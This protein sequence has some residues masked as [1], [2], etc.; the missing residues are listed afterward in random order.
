VDHIQIF[1]PFKVSRNVIED[2][3][4]RFTD[5]AIA[6]GIFNDVLTVTVAG[7]T[8]PRCIELS[9]PAGPL[10][11]V[12]CFNVVAGSGIVPAELDVQD[13][14]GGTLLT[15]TSPALRTAAAASSS[16]LA[17]AYFRLRMPTSGGGLLTILRPKDH[18][19]QSGYEVVEYIDFRL[20]EARTLPSSVETKMRAAGV[21]AAELKL[22]AFLTAVPILS[23]IAVSSSQS[24]KM[25]VLEHDL[26]ASYV[27]GQ[28]PTDMMVYHWKRERGSLP[29]LSGAGTL[30]GPPIQD[31]SAFI[32]LST[33]RTGRG[34]LALY[35]IIAFVFGI[36]GNLAASGIEA[37][38][39]L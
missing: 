6:Q 10:C 12:H 24:H 14:A 3:S 39:S 18:A 37:A 31:F 5:T 13:E 17:D 21:N 25:R 26:W 7:P 8:G 38:F 19:L 22:V 2:C 35:L 15:I 34:A 20:N 33:R 27:P 16:A 23:N 30:P 1:V 29:D 9:G 11:R 36:L 4:T 32:K 28:L